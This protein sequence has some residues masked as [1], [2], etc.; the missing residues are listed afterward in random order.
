MGD[1]P[2][3]RPDGQVGAALLAAAHDILGEAR[4]A[5][6]E[7]GTAEAVAVHEFRKAMKRWRAL[8]R[9]LE[10]TVGDEARRLR[11]EARD[12]ARG[13]AEARDAQAALDALADLSKAES[14]TLSERS[15]ASL[16]NR[17]ED[18]RE[19]A[20]TTTLTEAVRGRL[21]AALGAAAETVQG[22]PLD[23]MAFSE[24]A[25][26]L[27]DNYGRARRAMPSE[28]SQADPEDLHELRQRVVVHRYQMEL[29]EPLW[30]R[31]GKVWTGEAQRLRERLGAC[32]D[33]SVLAD[34]TKAHAPL[35]WWRSRLLPLIE[36]RRATHVAAAARLAGR[37]FAERP[38]GF[39]RRLQALWDSREA[40]G[41]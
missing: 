37:L 9:L 21:R 16:R 34:L 23:R 29:V 1:K 5:L 31:F 15:L 30:P 25:G 4:A 41:A 8:L 18:I 26:G 19:A 32:Q 40:A 36:A 14:A 39:R 33:H 17:I 35:A 3:L 11:T 38:K 2:R 7:P 28:W 13:L 27:A 6:A 12:L 24:V 10:P 20:E 22:W